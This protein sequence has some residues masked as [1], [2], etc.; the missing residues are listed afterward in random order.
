MSMTP[1]QRAALYIALVDVLPQHV[2]Y[3]LYNTATKPI[4]FKSKAAINK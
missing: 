3:Q 4:N 2:M 1:L